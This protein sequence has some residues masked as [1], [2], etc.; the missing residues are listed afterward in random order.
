M[1]RRFLAND[2]LRAILAACESPMEV[3]AF[4]I[5]MLA[6]LRFDE[7]R[8]LKWEKHRHPYQGKMGDGSWVGWE[9]RVIR[10]LGNFGKPRAAQSRPC[11]RPPCGHASP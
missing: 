5:L 6:G 1:E 8:R 9:H 2:E 7:I 4:L 3:L 10:V 11:R